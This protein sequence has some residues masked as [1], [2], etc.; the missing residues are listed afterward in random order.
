MSRQHFQDK[1]IGKIRVKRLTLCMMGNF[2]GVHVLFF[3]L[4]I[5]FFKINFF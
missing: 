2:V 4:L 5:F 1:N 3:S